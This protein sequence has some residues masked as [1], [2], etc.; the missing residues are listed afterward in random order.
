MGDVRKDVWTSQETV[1]DWGGRGKERDSQLDSIPNHQE[2]GEDTSATVVASKTYELAE[3]TRF[4]K[5]RHQAMPGQPL[6]ECKT[7]ATYPRGPLARK[8]SSPA[9]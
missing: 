2:G 6:L 5:V 3:L 9:A 1:K 7:F 8:R 4:T